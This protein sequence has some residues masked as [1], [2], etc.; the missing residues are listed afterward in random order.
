MTRPRALFALFALALA[1]CNA[2]AYDNNDTELAVR[3]KAKEMCSC[4]FV[5]ELS[6]QECAAW[7]RVSPDVAKATIDREHKRVHAVALGFWAADARF[8]GRHGCVHD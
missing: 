1:A 6:E 4:L 7:T 5:M 8:D 3:Q 2:E